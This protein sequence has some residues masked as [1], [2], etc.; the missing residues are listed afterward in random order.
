M[1]SRNDIV[2]AARQ[3]LGVPFRKGGRDKNSLDCVGLLI[4]IH[5]DLGLP[6]DDDTGYTFSPTANVQMIQKFVFGQSDPGGMVPKHG[7][8]AVMIDSHFPMHFGIITKD[9]DRTQFI[10]AN[11]K[12]RRVV[13]QDFGNWRSKL[14]H[15][16]EFKGLDLA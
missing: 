16:R 4:M 11:T 3:Y 6:I 5:K 12:E 13:E 14:T 9:G 8:I 15:L 1:V 10:N 7:Q 2:N